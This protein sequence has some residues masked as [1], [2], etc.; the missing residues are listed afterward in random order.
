MFNHY[1]LRLS[2]LK[3]E[4]KYYKSRFSITKGSKPSKLKFRFQVQVP[5]TVSELTLFAYNILIRYKLSN[6]GVSRLRLE[7]TVRSATEKSL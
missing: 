1:F 7:V 3:F 5:T 4:N 2:G 6:D